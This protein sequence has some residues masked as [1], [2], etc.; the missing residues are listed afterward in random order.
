V[1]LHLDDTAARAIFIV[2]LR[3][4]RLLWWEG[5]CDASERAVLNS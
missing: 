1:G 2:V 5:N 3:V 4:R